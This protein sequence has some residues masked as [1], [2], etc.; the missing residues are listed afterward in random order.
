MLRPLSDEQGGGF[1]LIDALGR[2]GIRL[3][4][5]GQISFGKA[6]LPANTTV[7]DN[8]GATLISRLLGAAVGGY[9]QTCPDESGYAFAIVDQNGRIG[10]GVRS[11]NLPLTGKVAIADRALV[12]DYAAASPAASSWTGKK[13]GALGDSNTANNVWPP[14]VAAVHGLL[15]TNCGV[16]G[17]KFAKPDSNGT[18]ISMCDDVRVNALPADAALITVA[19]GT[20]DWAQSAPM[21]TIT[22]TDNTTFYGA[23]NVTFGKVQARCP[24]ARILVVTTP[25][26]E[27]TETYASRGWTDPVTNLIGLTSRDYADAIR[28]AASRWGFPVADWWGENGINTA[29]AATL[30]NIEGAA[31]STIR[32]HFSDAGARRAASV[33]NGRLFDLNPPA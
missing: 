27:F 7:A 19:G 15:F 24:N 2:I 30:M 28:A 21:G 8:P 18:Q 25:Y 9:F 31:G 29:S 13:A 32:I 17:S 3:D 26:G 14:Y 5:A 16:G 6:L 11:A 10:F 4:G 1:A 12:A 33:I 20:N 23:L 22:S